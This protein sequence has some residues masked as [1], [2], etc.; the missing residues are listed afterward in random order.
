M[1]GSLSLAGH[2]A[3]IISRPDGS[4]ERPDAGGPLLGIFPDGEFESCEVDLSDGSSLVVFSDGF[5]LV[6]D[7]ILSA[8]KSEQAQAEPHIPRL[9]GLGMA[10]RRE[11]NAH[12]GPDR[13][14]GALRAM[15]N[16][17]DQQLGS[18]HQPDDLTVIAIGP[19][20]R[21][22]AVRHAA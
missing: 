2:P 21:T 6:Y 19:S 14:A 9:E 17:L 4:T 16:E 15:E 18:L 3:P 5:E 22:A 7:G 10:A 20:G 11:Q 12:D 1:R 8:P 13:L